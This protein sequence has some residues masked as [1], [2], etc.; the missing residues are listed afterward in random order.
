MDFSPLRL[1]LENFNPN[2]EKQYNLSGLP[3]AE[4][5]F[6][7][8]RLIYERDLLSNTKIRLFFLDFRAESFEYLDDNHEGYKV[9]I[10]GF[11]RALF[12]KSLSLPLFLKQRRI[13]A[14]TEKEINNDELP[15]NKDNLVSKL[16]TRKYYTNQARFS[17]EVL[18]GVERT[19]SFSIHNFLFLLNAGFLTNLLSYMSPKEEPTLNPSLKTTEDKPKKMT[20]DLTI[21]NALFCLQT[22]GDNE[23]NILALQ[24]LI[25]IKYI[26]NHCNPSCTLHT[27]FHQ[28]YKNSDSRLFNPYFRDFTSSFLLISLT[29]L[30]LFNC[31]KEDLLAKT[32]D[33][34]IWMLEI[35]KRALLQPSS[36]KYESEECL[37]HCVKS[38]QTQLKDSKLILG[39][40][41]VNF[42]FKDLFLINETSDWQKK[43]LEKARK[44]ENKGLF[45]KK[46][47]EGLEEEDLK[48]DFEEEEEDL[49]INSE[50]GIKIPLERG[51]KIDIDRRSGLNMKSDKIEMV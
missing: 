9:F 49:Y 17:L 51:E 26:K 45:R 31:N 3:F 34:D 21:R 36:L 2:I 32:E 5:S 4:L 20:I 37:C 18:T 27:S 40:T 33:S 1:L 11:L 19:L 25:Q 6:I 50:E 8:N 22:S 38:L 39:P 42:S 10:T 44:S 24:A 7:S 47:Y 13:R 48:E 23:E 16:R 15:Y 35:R 41:R 12:Q 46:S 29:K 30:E 43:E 28:D 14:P